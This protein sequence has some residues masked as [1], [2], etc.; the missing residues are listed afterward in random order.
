MK[1]TLSPGNIITSKESF[2]LYSDDAFVDLVK[3][4]NMMLVIAMK[5][6]K[7]DF[8]NEIMYFYVLCSRS[9]QFGWTRVSRSYFDNHFSV[10]DQT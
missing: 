5:T 7:D 8:D 4:D 1:T 9:G 3:K 2:F 10:L 6:E